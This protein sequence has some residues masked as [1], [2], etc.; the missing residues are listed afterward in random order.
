[1]SGDHDHLGGLRALF[2][3]REHVHPGAVGHHEVGEDKREWLRILTDGLDTGARP[4][5]GHDIVALPAECDV[6][7]LPEAG[8]IIDNK[9]SRSTCRG[10]APLGRGRKRGHGR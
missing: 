3:G 4:G 7:H 10:S 9:H 8:L 5:G 1:M 6:E 2:G